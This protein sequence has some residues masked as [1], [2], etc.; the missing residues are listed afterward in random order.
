MSCSVILVTDN[1]RL[2][3]FSSRRLT[4]TTQNEWTFKKK[5]LDS[6]GS[7][8]EIFFCINL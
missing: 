7:E 3:V 5:Q 2:L 1:V 4:L 8:T 6:V